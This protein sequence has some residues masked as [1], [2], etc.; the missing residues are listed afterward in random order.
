VAATLTASASQAAP[1]GLA[2]AAAEVALAG[3]GGALGTTGTAILAKGVLKMMFMAKG[4]VKRLTGECRRRRDHV[5]G[6]PV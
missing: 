6:W 5:T 2:A 1:A 4:F 3:V